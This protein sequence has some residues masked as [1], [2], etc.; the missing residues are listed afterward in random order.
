MGKQSSRILIDGQDAKQVIACDESGT[1]YDI[2]QIW[3]SDKASVLSLAW[4]K[5]KSGFQ[6]LEVDKFASFIAYGAS[7]F[8]GMFGT[9]FG[10]DNES[11]TSQDGLDYEILTTYDYYP[12]FFLHP[13]NGSYY[14]DA[15][16]GTTYEYFMALSDEAWVKKKPVFINPL[17]TVGADERMYNFKMKILNE[18]VLA[19]YG[20]N[21]DTIGGYGDS[22]YTYGLYTSSDMSTF[23][24]VNMSKSL[25]YPNSKVYIH[26][27]FEDMDIFYHDGFYYCYGGVMTETEDG[28]NTVYGYFKTSN[29]INCTSIGEISISAKTR[30]F[31][32]GFALFNNYE[33]DYSTLEYKNQYYVSYDLSEFLE[34]QFTQGSHGYEE[35]TLVCFENEKY[36]GFSAKLSE[37]GYAL[38]IIKKYDLSEVIYLEEVN[39]MQIDNIGTGAIN[40][41]VVSVGLD[42]NGTYYIASIDLEG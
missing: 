1:A 39:G 27:Y 13:Y 14:Y 7:G 37:G 16:L 36:F 35:Y 42:V 26:C 11:R 4:E 20:Q 24:A 31:F 34:V 15:Y 28:I 3:M 40:D 17:G 8:L 22:Q 9:E 29:F 38:H 30:T 5:L 25:Y 32:D 23:N 2:N 41:K 10:G 19:T 12:N 21:T 18:V 6:F 33:I